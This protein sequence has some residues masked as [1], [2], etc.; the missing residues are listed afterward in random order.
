MSHRTTRVLASVVAAAALVVVPAVAA[1]AGGSDDPTPYAVDAAGVTLPSGRTFAAHDHVN[2]RTN[3]G[4]GNRNVH[5]DPNNGHPGGRWIGAT[6]IPWSAFGL[7]GDFCVTWVQ[8]AGFNE[9]FGEGG[10]APWCT[11]P[12]VPVVPDP[13]VPDPVVPDPVVPDQVDPTEP[14]EPTD[15]DEPTAPTDPVEST[16]PTDPVDLPEPTDPVVPVVPEPVDPPQPVDPSDPV[17]P[18]LPIRPLAPADPVRTAVVPLRIPATASVDRPVLASQVLAVPD[19]QAHGVLATTGSAASG[20]A[21]IASGL[22]I[23]GTVVL[24]AVRRAWRG[25][26]R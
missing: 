21:L 2:V 8:V 17:T 9:H 7:D 24:A 1:Q 15:P 14:A 18:P 11:A 6:T 25:S 4:D 16:A 13:V 20:A 19:A 23:A 3:L 22:L 5:L 12:V 26:G 10:Q